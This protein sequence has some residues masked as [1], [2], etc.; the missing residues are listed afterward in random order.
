MCI[1]LRLSQG[2]FSWM[3]LCLPYVR[4]LLTYCTPDTLFCSANCRLQTIIELDSNF[5]PWLLYHLKS[6]LFFYFTFLVQIIASFDLKINPSVSKIWTVYFDPWNLLHSIC[7]CEHITWHQL[8][9]THSQCRG[10]EVTEMQINCKY[11]CKQVMFAK[12]L[13]HSCTRYSASS[14]HVWV[15][16]VTQSQ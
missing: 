4:M 1:V 5:D 14:C 9:C 10:I 7:P 13:C 6:Y 12:V 11:S 3:I 8:D 16:C 2:E 15:N